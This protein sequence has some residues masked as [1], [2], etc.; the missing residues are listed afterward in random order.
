MSKN[1]NE[2][3]EV[4]ERFKV[5]RRVRK[6]LDEPFFGKQGEGHLTLEVNKSTLT[7]TIAYNNGQVIT[8]RQDVE[9]Y[10]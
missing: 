8:H 7:C 2:A 6:S 1:E 10:A 3:F 4:L 9:Y 5:Q